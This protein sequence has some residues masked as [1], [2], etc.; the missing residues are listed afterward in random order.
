MNKYLNKKVLVTGAGGFIGSHLTEKLVDLNADVTAFIWHKA[1]ET[2]SLVKYL[3]VEKTGRIN[4]HFGDLQDYESLLGILKGIDIVFHLAAINSIHYSL[5]NPKEVIENNVNG[6][7]NLLVAARECG[8]ERIVLAS[9][10]GVYGPAVGLPITEKHG[11]AP[12]S[13]Y[14]AGKLAGE[15]IALSFYHSFALPVVILRPFNTF[16][17]RQSMRAVIPN[18][19]LQALHDG[20]VKLGRIDSTRDFNYVLNTAAGFTAAGI[21]EKIEGEIINIASGS[22]HSIEE[23]I[24]IV[25]NLLSTKLKIVIEDKRKRPGKSEA[26]RLCAS[27]KKAQKIMNYNPAV[28]FREGLKQTIDF[29]AKHVGDYDSREFEI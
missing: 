4:I 9:T 27:I 5:I 12:A 3:P 8:A 29:Y 26:D 19:I 21:T 2:N 28:S 18:I 1:K 11:T 7:L 14:T 15:E 25:E 6:T 10:A 17:P 20:E 16:G 24:D 13:P 23:V 22:E